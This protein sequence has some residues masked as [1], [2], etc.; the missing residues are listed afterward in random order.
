[1]CELSKIFWKE[2]R[3]IS[4]ILSLLNS[5][6]FISRYVRYNAPNLGLLLNAWIQSNLSI[7]LCLTTIGILS[8]P[9]VTLVLPLLSFYKLISPSKYKLSWI[10]LGLKTVKLQ[11]TRD[12][13]TIWPSMLTPYH[14]CRRGRHGHFYE[15]DPTHGFESDMTAEEIFN[16]FFGGGFPGQTVYVRRGDPTSRFRQGAHY[17]R[18]YQQAQENR[19]VGEYSS[20]KKN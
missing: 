3:K 2:V 7:L 10:T 4:N 13:C 9:N 19:E 16:M 8:G 11:F 12:M 15:N 20:H 17:Q 1:M 6:R 18:H 5:H 14:L